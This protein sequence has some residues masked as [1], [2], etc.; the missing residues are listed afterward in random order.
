MR[1]DEGVGIDPA[2]APS[3]RN[4]HGRVL[5]QGFRDRGVR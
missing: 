1:D 5:T 4:K 3:A 2:V